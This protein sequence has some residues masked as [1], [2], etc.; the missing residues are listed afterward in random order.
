MRVLA[1][2]SH[3]GG[4]GKTTLAGHLAVQ[5]QVVGAGPVVLIDVDPQ[6]TIGDWWDARTGDDPAFAQTSLQRLAT[7]IEILRRQDFR[8]AIVDTPPASGMVVQSVLQHAD[9][10]VIP[11]RPS[12]HDLRAAATTIELCHRLGKQVAFAINGGEANTPLTE[13]ILLA[14][15]QHGA[16]IPAMISQSHDFATSMANGGTVLECDPTGV[17]ASEIRALWQHI[18]ER[19]EKNFRRTVFSQPGAGSAPA[20][21]AS[22]PLGFGRR[23]GSVA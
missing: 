10:V 5:A 1:F 21:R 15:S 2:A 7:D 18:S 20:K 23:V 9:L 16:V 6:G 12:P 3:K 11:I 4:S 19:L 22:P 13:Q 17:P 8:L 14:L